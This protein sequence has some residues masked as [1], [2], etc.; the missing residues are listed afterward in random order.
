MEGSEVA[1]KPMR[2]NAALL[3]AV[4][5]AAQAIAEGAPYVD[6]VPHYNRLVSNV[7]AR[8]IERPTL[9]NLDYAAYFA[10][11]LLV[12][13]QPG[14]FKKPLVNAPLETITFGGT[15]AEVKDRLDQTP[16]FE[17]EKAS[18]LAWRPLVKRLWSTVKERRFQAITSS[19][20]GY[21][22]AD[23]SVYQAYQEITW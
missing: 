13:Q 5:C 19:I 16:L 22:W 6:L 14:K 11:P 15:L 18:P 9:A 2:I 23:S 4:I 10:N 12:E 8:H 7:M 1:V 20:N 3:V 21:K 17:K